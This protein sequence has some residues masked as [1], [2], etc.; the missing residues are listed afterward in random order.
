M[1]GSGDFNGLKQ[2]RNRVLFRSTNKSPISFNME[3]L[4]FLYL[5]MVQN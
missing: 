4:G 3:K 1:E 5:F 2:F